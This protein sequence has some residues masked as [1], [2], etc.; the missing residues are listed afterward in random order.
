MSAV[1]ILWGS[2]EVSKAN[3]IKSVLL[4]KT[5]SSRPPCL[6][7]TVLS[8]TKMFVKWNLCSVSGVRQHF[9]DHNNYIEPSSE[10]YEY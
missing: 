4:F 9:G 7:L 10:D 8:W 2:S 5:V 1:F 3:L 6:Q